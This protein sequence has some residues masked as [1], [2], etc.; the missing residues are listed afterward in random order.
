VKICIVSDS[1]ERAD[2][3]ARA[4]AQGTAFSICGLKV[5]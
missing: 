1:N 5:A 4:A 3:L 2:A